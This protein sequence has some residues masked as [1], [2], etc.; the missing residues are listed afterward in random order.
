MTKCPTLPLGEM[1]SSTP[2]SSLFITAD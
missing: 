1:R 2:T